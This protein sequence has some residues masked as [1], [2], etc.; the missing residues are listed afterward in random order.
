MSPA[1]ATTAD[2]R[3]IQACL[4]CYRCC[5]S[6]AAYCQ[7]AGGQ[8]TE[9]EHLRLLADCA[10][11]CRVSADFMIRRSASHPAVCGVCAEI[12]AR[13]ASDC[14]RMGDERMRSCADVCRRCAQQCQAMTHAHI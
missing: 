10:E 8:H 12:C 6:T 3:C 1:Q 5:L 7:A 9:A 14:E 11:I 4:D 2:E 13:C